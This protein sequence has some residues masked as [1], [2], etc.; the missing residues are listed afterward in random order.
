MD[1]LISLLSNAELAFVSKTMVII[2][3]YKICITYAK[4]L[5][6]LKI[7]LDDKKRKTIKK[8]IELFDKII[9]LTVSFPTLYY[10]LFT[11][12]KLTERLSSNSQNYFL[13]CSFVL[14]AYTFFDYLFNA[15]QDFIDNN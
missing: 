3:F 14:A 1:E 5:L 13:Q 15:I 7:S 4:F 10:A 6:P 8:S 2:V 12:L 11:Y 9:G